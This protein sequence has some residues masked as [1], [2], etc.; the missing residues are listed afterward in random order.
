MHG[1]LHECENKEGYGRNVGS[2][3]YT[4]PFWQPKNRFIQLLVNAVVL[5]R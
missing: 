3:M 2:R 1:V 5:L 4:Y